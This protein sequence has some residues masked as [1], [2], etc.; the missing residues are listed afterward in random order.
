MRLIFRGALWLRSI[1]V[2]TIGVSVVTIVGMYREGDR[3][4]V[5]YVPFMFILLGY[6]AWPRA[7]RLDNEEISKRDAF[8]RPTRI[9]RGEIASVVL[10]RSTGELVVFGQNGQRITYKNFDSDGGKMME[11]LEVLTGKET[12]F[13]G[14]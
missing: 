10:D 1:Y 5:L 7:I 14:F 13:L 3:G 8:F 11:Q 2:F 6:F 4:F 12:T 9:L